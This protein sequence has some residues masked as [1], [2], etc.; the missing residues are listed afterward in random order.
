MYK[1]LFVALLA[2]A[3]S[4][5]S[6]QQIRHD[7]DW[8]Q[9]SSVTTTSSKGENLVTTESIVPVSIE[10]LSNGLASSSMM[11]RYFVD[12][13]LDTYEIGT[14]EFNCET[15]RRGFVDLVSFNPNGTPRNFS[16]GEIARFDDFWRVSDRDMYEVV[17]ASATT[18][19]YVCQAAK[20]A[21]Q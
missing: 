12:G 10:P 21:K 9:I 1:P 18:L 4:L 6:A 7:D 2:A 11:V 8:K 16:H 5:A 19:D 20:R 15:H 17:G 14:A 13:H 3:P